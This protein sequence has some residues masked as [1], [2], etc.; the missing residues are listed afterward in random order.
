M[1]II[2]GPAF[3]LTRMIFVQTIFDADIPIEGRHLFRE[4]PIFLFFCEIPTTTSCWGTTQDD[5]RG[6]PKHG[7][8]YVCP[9]GDFIIGRRSSDWKTRKSTSMNTP[10]DSR[11]YTE[12]DRS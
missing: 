10:R 9:K 6:E 3:C 2:Q 4:I 7:G 11:E 8:A 1:V 5:V 12:Y